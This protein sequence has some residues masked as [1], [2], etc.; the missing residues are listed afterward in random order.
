MAYETVANL[1][2]YLGI[3]ASDTAKD[4]ILTTLLDVASKA[5]DNHTLRTFAASTDTTRYFDATRDVDSKR[6]TVYLDED[7]CSIT[8]IING[9][10]TSVL[11]TEYTPLPRNRT[12]WYAIELIRF[13]N[14]VWT[15]DDTPVDAIAITGKWGY[16]TTPD[17]VIKQCTIRLASYLFRQKDNSGDLDRTIVGDFG[18]L[19]PAELPKDLAELL[20]TYVRLTI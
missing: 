2:I 18:M 17:V 3:A 19:L 12:P 9:D 6:M 7:L 1:K 8:S 10:G 11:S 5:I 15:F 20:K 16:S 4:A 13:G 14:V